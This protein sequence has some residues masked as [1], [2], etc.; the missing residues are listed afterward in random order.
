MA[1]RTGT[2]VAHREMQTGLA[3][4]LHAYGANHSTV[5]R[6]GLVAIFCLSSQTAPPPRVLVVVINLPERRRTIV[7]PFHSEVPRPRVWTCLAVQNGFLKTVDQQVSHNRVCQ[8]VKFRGVLVRPT[9]R[10]AR[11]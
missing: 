2:E 9:I 11:I 3:I 4:V 8:L 10:W 1:L 5:A 7:A 6:E